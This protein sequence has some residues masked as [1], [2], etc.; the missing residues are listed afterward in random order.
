MYGPLI[1]LLSQEHRS[2]HEGPVPS[3]ASGRD[4]VGRSPTQG[5]A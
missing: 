1:D 3:A 2:R 4:S 5:A